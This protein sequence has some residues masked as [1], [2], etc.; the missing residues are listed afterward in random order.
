MEALAVVSLTSNIL[1]FVDFSCKL[2]DSVKTIS[3]CE[4]GS[5]QDVRL[6]EDTTRQFQKLCTNLTESRKN[7]PS[8]SV[9]MQPPKDLLVELAQ[10]CE[11]AA[12][13]FLATLEKLKAKDPNSRRSNVKAAFK[14]TWRE[15]Q[16]KDMQTRLQTYKS[17]LMIHLQV[18]HSDEWT[19]I[20]ALLNKIGDQNRQHDANITTQV[21]KL[22]VEVQNAVN[23]WD[24][25]KREQSIIAHEG[26]IQLPLLKKEDESHDLPHVASLIW[27]ELCNSPM[28][29]ALSVLNSLRFHMMEFRHS[30]IKEAHPNT[31]NWASTNLFQAWL[32]SSE[33][34]FWISGKP[35]SGKSTLMKFLVDNPS[36]PSMLSKWSGSRKLVISSYFFWINST[37]LQRSQE[38]L[39]RAILYEILRQ[40]PELAEDVLPDQCNTLKIAITNR[41]PTWLDW[42]RSVLLDAFRRLSVCNHTVKTKFCIFIDGLDEY[43][44]DT[45][46]PL[47]DLIKT[48]QHLTKMDAKICVASRPWNEFEEAFGGNPECKVYLQELNKPDIELYVSGHLETRPEFKALRIKNDTEAVQ[49]LEEVVKKSQ[50]VFLWVYLVVHSLIEGLRNQDR[51]PELH[52]RLRRFPSDLEEFFRHIFTT[53]EPVYR[54]QTAHMFQVALA[55]PGPLSPIAYWYMD[56]AEE[57]APDLA[58]SMPIQELTKDELKAII[59]QTNA[60]LNG[61]CKGL[62]EM[63]PPVWGINLD[64]RVDFLHRTVRDFFMMSEIHEIFVIEQQTDFN[65]HMAICNALLAQLK[66]TVTIPSVQDAHI[67][68]SLDFFFDAA[69]Y[70]EKENKESPTKYLDELELTLNMFIETDIDI[71]SG[72]YIEIDEFINP[73]KLFDCDSFTELIFTKDLKIYGAARMSLY[74][75]QQKQEFLGSLLK[76]RFPSQG[77]FV[78]VLSSGPS[79]SFDLSLQ[80]ALARLLTNAHNHIAVDIMK[81]V[82]QYSSFSGQA[83]SKRCPLASDDLWRVLVKK[84]PK[85]ELDSILRAITSASQPQAQQPMQ[86]PMAPASQPQAQQLVQWPWPNFFRRLL[87]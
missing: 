8:Q 31:Y 64:Y 70:L 77:V 36:T 87:C 4:V 15:R 65:A 85:E 42:P 86:W 25:M 30:E 40:C 83:A 68:S 24:T 84:L 51:L 66:S 39:L 48:I 53:L 11:A 69:G 57:N 5:A 76:D 28:T 38:G 54:M 37:P 26:R 72:M 79:I 3:E 55:A 43:K 60:R 59:T 6:L 63:T 61:R 50:G 27:Q 14:T 73:W 41:R 81:A 44:A 13:E 67:L 45:K 20:T 16:V 82:S 46:H 78:T 74:T 1:Q 47:D 7:V 49:I 32:N 21:S 18:M 19:H 75:A 10:G 58:I 52:E 29:I 17:Q 33:P 35:G 9:A 22:T 80:Q 71:E 2:F 12:A 23:L 62:L 56:E 34:V